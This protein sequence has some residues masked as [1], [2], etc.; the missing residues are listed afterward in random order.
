[1][2]KEEIYNE[3]FELL[4]KAELAARNGEYMTC[5]TWCKNAMNKAY[6]Y[7]NAAQRPASGE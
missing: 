1:M 5:G 4:H 2:T 3:L 6:E 7:G